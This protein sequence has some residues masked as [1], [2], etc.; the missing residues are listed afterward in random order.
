MWL[1][2]CLSSL[3]Q[4]TKALDEF[5]KV[6][7]L[8]RSISDKRLEAHALEGL[9][10]AYLE[11]GEP[12]LALERYS[13][14]RALAAEIGDQLW[15][16][17]S[18]NGVAMARHRRGDHKHALSDLGEALT[19]SDQLK[20]RFATSLTLFNLAR[21]ESA[22]DRLDQALN[23]IQ[24]SL[25]LA[26]TLRSDVA[27]LDLRAS[28]LASIRERQ[29]LEIDLLMRLAERTPGG[30]FDR[31]AFDA[32]ERARAR[33]FLDG[34]A[35]TRASIREGVSPGLLERE[36]SIQ[37]SLN[38]KAQQLARVQGQ[39][40]K[41]DEASALRRDID[42]ITASQQEIEAQIR[43]ESPRYAGL[44]QPKPLGL[45][46]VQTLVV[47]DQ[48][49]L[50][51][52][53]IGEIRSYV[54][55]VTQNEIE[56]FVLPGRDEIDRQVRSY[57][58]A[59]T[60]PASDPLAAR[61][62]SSARLA[63]ARAL[64]RMLL[65]PVSGYL[66]H[67]RVLIVADGVLHLLPFSALPDPRTLMSD[68]LSDVPLIAEHELVYLPSAST[69]ALVRGTWNQER[70]WPRTARIFA[71]AVFEADDPRIGATAHRTDPSRA[72]SETGH[73]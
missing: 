13:E 70:R 58:A 64:S 26:E 20:S 44:T 39:G 52:Y 45:H 73:D 29:E 35:E 48:S 22:L 51:Q 32:S 4:Q 6:L 40:G 19:L 31:L 25:E 60:A 55:A 3:G 34:L 38:A 21:V 8:S 54:W 24:T 11:R 12:Q 14:S 10:R 53:F 59:L 2:A 61:E 57:R 46:D 56:G 62:P 23:H 72:A 36:Q 69:L 50:L 42:A 33:S 18:L 28:Y 47:N 41:G 71:D 17:N 5:A 27:S 49:V 7:V 30:K 1:G 15:V 63:D 43:A 16:I 67:P 68:T 9:G 37:R 66:S 65:G